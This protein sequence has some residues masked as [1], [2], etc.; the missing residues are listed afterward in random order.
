MSISLPMATPMMC[1]L[2]SIFM[3]S[4]FQSHISSSERES[5]V[6]STPI[7]TL[8]LF[9]LTQSMSLNQAF[10]RRYSLPQA[11]SQ[12]LK[13]RRVVT[14]WNFVFGHVPKILCGQSLNVASSRQKPFR[15]SSTASVMMSFVSQENAASLGFF[16]EVVASAVVVVV[17]LLLRVRV[18]VLVTDV[19]DVV[20]ADV[21]VIV[22]VAGRVVVVGGAT[23]GSIVTAS[24]P[25]GMPGA[26]VGCGGRGAGTGAGAGAGTIKGGGTV[27]ADASTCVTRP[28]EP[29]PSAAASRSASF[30]EQ[31]VSVVETS[32]TTTHTAM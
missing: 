22:S 24:R 16:V 32:V 25:G 15:S 6:T 21:V 31:P 19:A 13:S 3:S 12:G 30:T 20:V 5:Q 23:V 27:E 29:A 10:L 14:F 9:F 11:L 7:R 2:P 17:M 4:M 28:A 18:R 26:S 8:A 1:S